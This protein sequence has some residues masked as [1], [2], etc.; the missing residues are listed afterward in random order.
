MKISEI[1]I[2][3]HDLPVCNGPYKMSNS[4]VN[5]LDTTIVELVTNTGLKGYGETCPVGPTYQ[6]QHALGAR[7]ALEQ[8]CP[9][10][11]GANP[12]EV[13]SMHRLM[14]SALNGHNYAKAAIDIGLYDLM[15]KHF[16]VR[17]CDLLGGSVTENV[18]SYYATG[19]GEPDEVAK[20][21]LEKVNEGFPRLQIKV[22]GRDVQIDIETVK[23]VRES[24]GAE[25][26]L[27]AD[28]NRSWTTKDALFFSCACKDIPI[29]L[30]QPCN[31]MTEIAAIRPQLNH[32]VYLDENTEDLNVI[33]EAVGRGL[34]DGFG[35][36]V[37]RLGGL[38]NMRTVREV[39]QVRSLPHT[40]DDSWGGDIIAAACTHIGATVEP[41]LNEGVWVAQPYID[42]HYDEINPLKVEQGH[43]KVPDQPGL[44]IIPNTDL[45]GSPVTSFV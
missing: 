4:W 1:H 6:P 11:I 12:L 16:K 14:E 28:A 21:A 20:I 7:A 2:Y 27:A 29:I 19:V 15:G 39:C 8:I 34:C 22:G 17:V 33:L 35:L 41:R 31:T 40:C 30:E 18:P 44:G 37:T 9:S 42:H 45:F 36:K 43:I 25:V 10:L 5:T 26:R 23:K 38:T 24:V 32:P 13:S 3:Q